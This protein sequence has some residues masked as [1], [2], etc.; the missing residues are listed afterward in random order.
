MSML[1]LYEQYGRV[2][3]DTP[4]PKACNPPDDTPKRKHA[5]YV[6]TTLDFWETDDPEHHARD[7]DIDGVMYRRLD[8]EYHAWLKRKMAEVEA[9]VPS[10]RASGVDLPGL[11]SRWSLV[12]AWAVDQLGSAELD[13]ALR[14]LDVARYVPP[15]KDPMRGRIDAQGATRPPCEGELGVEDRSS[16][17]L[18]PADGDWK[19]SRPVGKDAV[20]KVDAIRDNALSLGWT[21]AQLYQNRGSLVFPCSHEYGLV[22]F[23][24]DGERIGAVTNLSIEIIGAPPRE[25]ISHFYNWEVDQPWMKRTLPKKTSLIE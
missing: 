24:D 17:H 8:P 13:A 15:S 19:C 12:D 10:G 20:A 22:C 9:R 14:A 1:K 5:L 4:K 6:A 7:I 2:E 18:F 21:E 16:R 23:L 3:P 25:T 11:R